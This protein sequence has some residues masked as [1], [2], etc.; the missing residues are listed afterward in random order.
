MYAVLGNRS[1]PDC[2]LSPASAPGINGIPLAIRID[3]TEAA[4]CSAKL[5]EAAFHD[6]ACQ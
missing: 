3:D 5:C 1:E 6:H 4:L 2:V